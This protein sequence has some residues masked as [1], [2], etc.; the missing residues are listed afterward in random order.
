MHTPVGPEACFQTIVLTPVLAAPPPPSA[1]LLNHH[2]TARA[3]CLPPTALCLLY[4]AE[5][6]SD[7]RELGMGEALALLT[8]T[9]SIGGF[10]SAGFAS[11]HQ[12]RR[13]GGDTAM[14]GAGV[15]RG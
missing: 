7:P 12:V 10:Q 5:A 1:P 6:H 3:L 9:L 8:A 15:W 13:G 2:H 4:L 14:W 11:N